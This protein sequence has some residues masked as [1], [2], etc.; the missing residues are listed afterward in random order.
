M[1]NFFQ[2]GLPWVPRSMSYFVSQLFSPLV[3]QLVSVHSLGYI[4]GASPPVKICV[5]V[6]W[7]TICKLD[8]PLVTSH[9]DVLLSSITTPRLRSGAPPACHPPAPRVDNNRAKIMWSESG[10]Q[11]YQSCIADNL[12]RLRSNWLNS[13]SFCSFSVDQCCS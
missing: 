8:N 12:S 2:R 9:H 6:R 11:A 7:V 1:S 13:L 5:S 4:V 10:I 3:S